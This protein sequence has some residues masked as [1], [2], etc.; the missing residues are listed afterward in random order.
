MVESL[1]ELNQKCQ[2]P[3]YKT[4]GNWMVRHFER[5]A[6]LY[7]TWVVLHTSITANQVS[8]FAIFTAIVGGY[9]LSLGSVATFLTGVLL[10]QLWYLLDHVDGQVARYR[11]TVSSEGLFLDYMMHHFVNIIMPFAIGWGTYERTGDV[12]VIALGFAASVSLEFVALLNDCRAKTV[13]SHIMRFKIQS[14]KPKDPYAI[15]R[16]PQARSLGKKAF[17]FLHKSCEGHVFMNV[18]SVFAIYDLVGSDWASKIMLMRLGLAYYAVA[19]TLVWS[20]KALYWISKK[21]LTEEI[22]STFVLKD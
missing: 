19:A 3:N 21:S 11:K 5:D 2:K 14:D 20:V 17:S 10:W 9:F 13:L 18:W 4:V 8:Y 15:N 16:V 12:T 7:L 1:K 6:A 22:N